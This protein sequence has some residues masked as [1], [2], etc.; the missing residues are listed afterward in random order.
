MILIVED[1]PNDSY[2]LTVQLAEFELEN[3]IC[4]IPNGRRA[5]DFLLQAS[6]APFA[7]FL[8]LN[9]PGMGGVQL[10]QE[11][12]KEPRLHGLPVIVMT[13]SLDPEDAEKCARLGV[14]AYSSK[15]VKTEL[16]RNIILSGNSRWS[17]LPRPIDPHLA[18]VA[19][20][21]LQDGT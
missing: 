15:P 10:L 5:L 20:A 4:V 11:I 12:R 13:G 17:Y 18:D 8:D 19:F 6:P 14:F 9:L 7:L 3:E 16:L 2:L 1:D 21:M